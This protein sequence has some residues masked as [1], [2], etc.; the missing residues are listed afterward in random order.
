MEPLALIPED[1]AAFA[2]TSEDVAYTHSVLAQRFLPLRGLPKGTTSYEVKHGNA[3]LA[4][5]ARRLLN[6]NTGELERQEVPSGPAARL[7]IGHIQTYVKRAPSLDE[8]CRVPMGDSV[9]EFFEQYG[10]KWGGINGRGITRQVR[11]IAAMHMTIGIWDEGRAK[12][13]NVP[14]FAQEI[15]FW[16]EKDHRQRVL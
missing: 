2:P 13:V 3:S 16:L 5:D 14:A 10:K 4:I 9:H 6:P 15:E 8:A 11:N 1:V 7:A 12:Q